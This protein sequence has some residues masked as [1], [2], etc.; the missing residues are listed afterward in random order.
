MT[1][2]AVPVG[3][4]QPDGR[5]LDVGPSCPVRWKSQSCITP[6]YGDRIRI[7]SRGSESNGE[8]KSRGN[9]KNG[10]KHLAWARVPE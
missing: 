4:I 8:R 7:C 9:T 6:R 1:T 10:D 2:K 5:R 3:G